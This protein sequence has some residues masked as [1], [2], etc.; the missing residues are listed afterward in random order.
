MS[1][2]VMHKFFVVM[3]LFTTIFG[4]VSPSSGCTIFTITDGEVVL[5]G[6]NEDNFQS[7]H[8]RI[9]SYPATDGKYGLIL[10]GFR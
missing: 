8:G 1:I 10:F 3:I 7:R 4:F 2:R 9:W 6:N 5:F